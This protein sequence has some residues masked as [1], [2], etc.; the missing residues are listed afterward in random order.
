MTLK[1]INLEDC[2]SYKAAVIT[3]VW[4]W[5]KGR[6]IG[7]WYGIEKIKIDLLIYGKLIFNTGSNGI[8]QRKYGFFNK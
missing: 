4:Y 8:P 7:Q 6:Q 5:S 3:I 2:E 1:K